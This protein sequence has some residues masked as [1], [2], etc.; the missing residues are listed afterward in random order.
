[1]LARLENRAIMRQIHDETFRDWAE[2]S[3][4][5][6]KAD[7]KQYIAMLPLQVGPLIETWLRYRSYDNLIPP[8]IQGIER[9]ESLADFEVIFGLIAVESSSGA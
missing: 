7:V 9:E 6:K 4:D 5:Q 1:L 3:V 2:C 8:T